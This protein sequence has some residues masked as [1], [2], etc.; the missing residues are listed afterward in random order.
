MPD[1]EDDF[2]NNEN[3]HDGEDGNEDVEEDETN[4]VRDDVL[5]D[6]RKLQ[7]QA[8]EN[9][10]EGEQLGLEMYSEDEEDEDL[11]SDEALEGEQDPEE[12]HELYYSIRRELMQGLP[13]GPKNKEL[14]QFVYNEKNLYLNRGK[15]KDEDGIRGSD[16][17]QTY[18]SHLSKALAVTRKWR[19][20]DGNAMDIYSAFR[21]MNEEAGYRS[22]ILQDQE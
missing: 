2:S 4:N 21:R 16:G 7:E 17:R 9:R 13:S 18:L 15:E 20:E 19:R 1:F 8:E 12:A 14:R 10:I 6:I 5:E 3:S 11:L 22:D